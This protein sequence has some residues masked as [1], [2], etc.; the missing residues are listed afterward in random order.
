MEALKI[1]MGSFPLYDGSASREYWCH[2][3]SG[4]HL[5]NPLVPRI[6]GTPG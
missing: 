1:F 3:I 4:Y 5:A 6:S 2:G